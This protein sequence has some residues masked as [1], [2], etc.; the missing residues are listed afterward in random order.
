[1]LTP[2]LTVTSLGIAHHRYT[3]QPFG[4]KEADRRLH[5]YVIGQT[6]TGKTTLLQN[7]AVQDAWAKRNFI[8]IDPHGDMAEAL[9]AALGDACLYWNVA[10]PASPY[11]YN[12]I[13]PVSPLYRPL[14]ASGLLEALKKQW[15]VD[16][17]GP[18]MEHLLRYS[19]LL[20][21]EQSQATL[22]DI[23]RLFV[24]KQ[25]RRDLTARIADP[26]VEYFWRQEFPSMNYK[27]A[28]DGFAPISNKLGAFLAHPVIRRA[29]CE[30]EEPL[31]F[32]KLMDNGER[33]IVNLAKG[34]L[35]AD[36]ANVL[37]GLL[38]ASVTNAAFSR[39]DLPE[40][41]RRDCTLIID[42]FTSLTTTALADT[43]AEARKYRLRLVLA[44]QFAAQMEPAVFEAVMG[45]VGN[46]VV[47]RV[48]VRDAPLLQQ[49]LST[50]SLADLINQ[51]NHR[52][53]LRVM[54]DGY[55][56]PTFSAS[57]YPSLIQMAGSSG[58]I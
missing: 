48:G 54:V 26:Q 18:R 55:R 44:H 57:L 29:V 50:V 23:G 5:L 36:T 49:Q 2:H 20:L 8:L 10:D 38:V 6:G 21:L 22:T 30:P 45:N 13:A 9:H 42:E 58:S 56:T 34:K 52:A 33:L 15:G 25:F 27:N 4:I 17:W 47:L 28:A 19:L 53:F 12:P 14:V 11:G 31:R 3:P 39:H 37:G 46:M 32:R 35:G 16:A 24:D 41:E 51:P 1:M 7:L 43:L 40:Q